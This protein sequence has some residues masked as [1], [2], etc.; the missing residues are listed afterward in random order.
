MSVP[1]EEYLEQ[2]D[3]VDPRIFRVVSLV[4]V[5]GLDKVHLVR[6][7]QIRRSHDRRDE[8]G[9]LSARGSVREI[10]RASRFQSFQ[11]FP[12]RSPGH[13]VSGGQYVASV[14]YDSAAEVM[15]RFDGLQRHLKPQTEQC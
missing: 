10:S 4:H 15:A 2:S 12:P 11:S 7:S 6:P 9:V 1:K 5:D 3:I 14:K 13:A 8:R